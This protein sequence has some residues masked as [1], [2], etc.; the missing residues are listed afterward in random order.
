MKDA[1]GPAR[2]ALGILLAFSAGLLFALGLAAGGMTEPSKVVGFLDVTGRWD[3]SLAFV[4]LG[5]VSVFFVADQL[6][7]RRTAP[8]I[9][10]RFH[11]PERR[12]LDL[13]LLVGA[14]LFGVG[15]GLSGYCPGPGLTSLATGST[16]PV[17][18]VAAMALGML[19]GEAARKLRARARA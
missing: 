4:M 9:G 6:A 19:L 10:G 16:R 13:P 2:S 17:V 18:F 11:F 14:A 7:R 15:W 5:A 1:H 3:P 12:T 8:L